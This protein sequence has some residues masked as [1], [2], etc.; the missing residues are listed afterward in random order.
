[1]HLCTK[2]CKCLACVHS[3]LLFDNEMKLLL[4][5]RTNVGTARDFA[6]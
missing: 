1:M 4:V 2:H 6:S 5:G 3:S